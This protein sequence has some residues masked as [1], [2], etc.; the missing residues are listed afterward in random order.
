MKTWETIC[1]I[2]KNNKLHITFSRKMILKH[3]YES[4]SSSSIVVT[5]EDVVFSEYFFRFLFVWRVRRTFFPSGWCFFYLVTTGWIFY[6]SLLCKNST[7]QS[8]K[9]TTTV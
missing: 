5:V 2:E 1:N 9:K 8:I 3:K 6:I 7:N 4:S